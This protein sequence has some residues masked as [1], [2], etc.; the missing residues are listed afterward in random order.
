M[1]NIKMLHYIQI[2]IHFFKMSFLARRAPK[3]KN[4][5]RVLRIIFSFFKPCFRE[6]FELFLAR[7]ASKAKTVQS[8]L[9]TK[10]AIFIG[11][12]FSSE[13]EI[14]KFDDPKK[15]LIMVRSTPCIMFASAALQAENDT[16]SKSVRF[17]LKIIFQLGC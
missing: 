5:Q 10:W 15:R 9:G 14:V 8:V 3:A 7:R 16:I 13:L 4:F 2:W 17:S 11:Y 1:S 6:C 12:K